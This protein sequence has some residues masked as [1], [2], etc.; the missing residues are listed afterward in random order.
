MDLT[1]L[2]DIAT[3]IGVA[4]GLFALVKGIFEYKRQGAQKRAEHF[5]QMRKRLK[6][7]ETFKKI[8][9]LLETDDNKLIS[10]PFK[11]KRDYLGLF[12]EVAIMMN[13]NLIKK[14]VAHYMFGYYAIKCWDSDN[15][16]NGVNRDSIYWKVFENFVYKMKYIE[17]NYS[18]SMENYKF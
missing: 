10:I 9:G 2:K 11:E 18:F 17:R 13:S 15:F 4:V 7:N 14:E 16:W 3:I 5:L 12:E 1:K 8:A 6:E